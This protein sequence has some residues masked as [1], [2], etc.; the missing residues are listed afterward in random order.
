M[1]YE[2]KYVFGGRVPIVRESR[3]RNKVIPS[4]FAGITL[5]ILVYIMIYVK[6]DLLYGNGA[7]IVIY[8]SFAA[9]AFILFVT[10]Y[11]RAAKVHRFLGSY[12]IAGLIGAASYYIYNLVGLYATTAIVVFAMSLIMIETKVQHPPAMG[13]AF[14]FVLFHISYIGVVIVALGAI[15]ILGMRVILEA[16]VYDLEKDAKRVIRRERARK[17]AGLFKNKENRRKNKG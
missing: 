17:N 5:A 3:L 15:I 9:S 16:L 12:I 8:S 4:I 13:I 1:E 7:S 14:A 10:P 2:E 6:F 11:A